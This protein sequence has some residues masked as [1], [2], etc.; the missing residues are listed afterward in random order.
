MKKLLS[1]LLL[2]VGFVLVLGSDE[3]GTTNLELI[4]QAFIGIILMI[5]GISWNEE[6]RKFLP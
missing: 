4:T 3:P 1:Y 6:M 5:A 2:F